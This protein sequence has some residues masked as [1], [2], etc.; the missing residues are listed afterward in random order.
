[1]A[2]VVHAQLGASCDVQAARGLSQSRLM[3]PS[4]AWSGPPP[5]RMSDAL[6]S[7]LTMPDGRDE[8]PTTHL[9]DPVGARSNTLQHQSSRKQQTIHTA[10]KM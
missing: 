1:M 8:K 9:P 7:D 5:T 6:R 3:Q 4:P 10:M 2:D